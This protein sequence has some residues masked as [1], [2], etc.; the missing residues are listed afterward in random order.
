LI[1]TSQ[2]IFLSNSGL[3]KLKRLVKT[4]EN[5]LPQRDFVKVVLVDVSDKFECANHQVVAIQKNHFVDVNIKSELH[6]SPQASLNVKISKN[7]A[8][9]SKVKRN[10]DFLTNPFN[11]LRIYIID[12]ISIGRINFKRFNVSL[13]DAVNDNLDFLQ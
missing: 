8:S 2:A 11:L 10:Q 1:K 9:M 6:D 7:C 4:V 5:G 3:L 13:L 12:V